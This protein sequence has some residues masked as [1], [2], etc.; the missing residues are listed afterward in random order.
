MARHKHET[1]FSVSFL[2]RR[3]RLDSAQ[4]A[5]LLFDATE[6]TDGYTTKSAQLSP[7][8]SLL[9]FILVV[10]VEKPLSFGLKNAWS[11]ENGCSV[12]CLRHGARHD[13]SSTIRRGPL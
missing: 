6:K 12:D 9:V 4:L 13:N 11:M 7:Q 1:P 8:S 2:C 10:V 5:T 3:R